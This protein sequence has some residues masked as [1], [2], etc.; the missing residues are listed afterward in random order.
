MSSPRAADVVTALG[1]LA[2][3]LA[4][5]VII[6]LATMHGQATDTPPSPSLR[7]VSDLPGGEEFDAEGFPVVDWDWWQA[8]NP[9][10]VGWVTIP[11]TSV[12]HPVVQAPADDPGFYLMHDVHRNWN[13]YG[14][15]YLDAECGET[16]LMGSANAVVEGHHMDDGSMLAPLVRYSDEGWASEHAEILVQTPEAK[17][18]LSVLAADVADAS[19]TPK[20]T[21]FADAQD[22]LGWAGEAVSNSAVVLD[23]G[24]APRRMYTFATCSYHRWRDERTLVFAAPE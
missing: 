15:V 20:R 22:Y 6:V 1:A 3:V 12:N 13:F 9:D 4:A 16:G 24:T 10:V 19:S 2:L 5:V 8:E 17:A 14:A 11:G 21:L 7:D 18:R 23:G